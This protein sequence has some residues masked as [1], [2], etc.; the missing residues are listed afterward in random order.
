MRK[1][2][3]FM[4]EINKVNQ[5]K[6]PYVKAASEIVQF[7][8]VDVLTASGGG[9]VSCNISVFGNGCTNGW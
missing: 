4:N 1:E 7:E 2:D 8:N 6:Q 3:F 9:G 5:E